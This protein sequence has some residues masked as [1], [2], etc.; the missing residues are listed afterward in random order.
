MQVDFSEM[1]KV[2]N[3]NMCDILFEEKMIDSDFFLCAQYITD[4]VARTMKEPPYSWYVID[5]LFEA[6]K[7]E[8][9]C[10]KWRQA[11]DL[12]FLLCS[13]FY[14][15]TNFRA[16]K[17]EDYANMGASFYNMFFYSSKREIG[18]HMSRNYKSMVSVT[19]RALF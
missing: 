3:S 15:R 17:Y 6:N 8:S 13:I 4:M 7:K 1:K 19:Q 9:D 16:M 14:E 2:L 5:Y 10:E 18:Y 12:C 11:A